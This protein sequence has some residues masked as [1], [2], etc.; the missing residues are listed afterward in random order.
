MA[1]AL[2]LRE[3]IDCRMVDNR[4]CQSELA[5]WCYDERDRLAAVVQPDLA[6][7][8]P[9]FAVAKAGHAPEPG[10]LLARDIFQCVGGRQGTGAD[11]AVPLMAGQA[12]QLGWA[13]VAADW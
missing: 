12:A 9:S 5:S 4:A 6:G 1:G 13:P 11:T 3:P 2:A 7:L 10:R 8:V